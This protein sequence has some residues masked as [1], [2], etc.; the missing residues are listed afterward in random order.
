MVSCCHRKSS[1]SVSL[2]GLTCIVLPSLVFFSRVAAT[3]SDQPALSSSARWNY[4]EEEE[5]ILVRQ[6]Q[7]LS[8]TCTVTGFTFLDVVRIDHRQG[9]DDTTTTSSTRTI[10][11]NSGIKLPYSDL[12]RYSVTFQRRADDGRHGTETAVVTLNYRG[13]Q[14]EDSG[15]LSCYNLRSGKNQ[16]D[17][18]ILNITVLVGVVEIYAISIKASSNSNDSSVSVSADDGSMTRVT[19]NDDT[20][21][22]EENKS[23]GVGCVAVVNGS[24]VYPVTQVTIDDRNVTGLFPHLFGHRKFEKTDS[25]LYQFWTETRS[26]LI[27]DKP[28]PDFDGKVLKCFASTAV[29]DFGRV[30]ASALL[31][32]RYVPIVSC[33]DVDDDD[34]VKARVGDDVT[35]ACS[36]RSNPRSKISWEFSETDEDEDRLTDSDNIRFS[37]ILPE[38]ARKPSQV[39]MTVRH[40]KELQFRGY[41]LTAVNAIGTT[42][43]TFSL[44]RG[45]ASAEHQS[46][47]EGGFNSNHR[48]PNQDGIDSPDQ[49]P[50]LNEPR[51]AA[52]NGRRTSGYQTFL[53]LTLPSFFLIV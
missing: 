29:G 49:K 34:E 23:L 7:D 10:S 42:N 44:V 2:L 53:F 31:V 39:S 16:K 38:D 30:S 13:I 40:V 17:V 11:D 25:G 20:V 15:L 6:G 41:A 1:C 46:I 28:D 50:V 47:N 33:N 37:E 5:A 48:K 26:A 27:T 52:M 32:V 51:N 22:L 4:E 45:T 21:V 24:G 9:S 3:G 12:A 43:V 18:N 36:V 19:R 14:P 8:V 35:I